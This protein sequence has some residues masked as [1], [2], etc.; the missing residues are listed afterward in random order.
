MQKSVSFFT[1]MP[2]FSGSFTGKISWQASVTDKHL[3]T[4][5]LDGGA[6]V[7]KSVHMPPWRGLLNDEQADEMVAQ[8][9]RFAK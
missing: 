6:A 1:A 3:R 7:G 9:R 5:I 4:A 8:I 2:K